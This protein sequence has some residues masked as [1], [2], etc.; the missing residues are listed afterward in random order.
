MRLPKLVILTAIL[1]LTDDVLAKCKF[2]VS[3]TGLETSKRYTVSAT[4]TTY[5]RFEF[6]RQSGDY[7]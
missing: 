4:M 3:E 5:V 1:I 2:D 6:W 7:L